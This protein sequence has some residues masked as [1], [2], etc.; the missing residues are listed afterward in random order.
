MDVDQAVRQTQVIVGALAAGVALL[1]LV[2]LVGGLGSEQADGQLARILLMT[3]GMLALL[4]T[5]AYFVL[6]GYLMNRLRERRVPPE[7]MPA[8]Y[9]SFVVIRSALVEAVALFGAVIYLVT[10]VEIALV[11]PFAGVVLLVAQMPTRERF[12]AFCAEVRG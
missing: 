8:E 5:S 4:N 12:E 9:R 1:T 11:I 10:A 6:R 2:F 7:S 3:V